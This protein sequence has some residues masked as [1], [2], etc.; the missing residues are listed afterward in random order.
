MVFDRKIIG[1]LNLYHVFSIFNKDHNLII[2]ANLK[3][4]DNNKL[5]KYFSKNTKD[6]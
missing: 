3:I 5:H 2:T 4:I 1:K 6:H